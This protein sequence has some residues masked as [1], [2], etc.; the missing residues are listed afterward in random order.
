MPGTRDARRSFAAICDDREGLYIWSRRVERMR[1]LI[2]VR[3]RL[4]RPERYL[5]KAG[6]RNRQCAAAATGI[7]VWR[8]RL[9]SVKEGH[10]ENSQRGMFAPIQCA[11]R[12]G[13]LADPPKIEEILLFDRAT[14]AEPG[15]ALDRGDPICHRGIHDL[16]GLQRSAPRL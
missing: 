3:G 16:R 13:R 14:S 9:N 5:P 8:R 1:G 11:R 7:N 15:N 2:R 10:L 4:V 12:S 6:T